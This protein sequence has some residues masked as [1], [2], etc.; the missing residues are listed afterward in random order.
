MAEIARGFDPNTAEFARHNQHRI[1][2]IVEQALPS[3]LEEIED[4]E[5]SEDSEPTT[6][7][8]CSVHQQEASEMFLPSEAEPKDLAAN[9]EPPGFTSQKGAGYSSNYPHSNPTATFSTSTELIG[10][11]TAEID[12]ILPRDPKSVCPSAKISLCAHSKYLK[13][14]PAETETN[15][16]QPPTDIILSISSLD[17]QSIL[18]Q[19]RI[20]FEFVSKRLTSPP[21]SVNRIWFYV[22]APEFSLISYIC[23]VG[24]MTTTDRK[25][26]GK[27]K[28]SDRAVSFS[29]RSCYRLYQPLALYTLEQQFGLKSVPRE[30]MMVP[31]PTSLLEAVPW[32]TQQ[33]VWR[34]THAPISVAGAAG[35][36]ARMK[37]KASEVTD[38][39]GDEE[40]HVGK[41][42]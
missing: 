32:H 18:Y 1:Y 28:T 5:E 7:L 29:I 8:N 14:V 35:I 34:L 27:K 31:V 30:G 25:T 38:A 6:T 39:D 4:L 16:P 3:R 40:T 33:L 21:P 23:E 22:N 9:T 41:Q 37:R 15:I 12:R 36:K 13:I 20:T 24:T 11:D 19:E 10:V 42:R 26:T 2:E 17:V